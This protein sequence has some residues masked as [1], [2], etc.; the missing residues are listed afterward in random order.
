MAKAV[1]VK[2]E[3]VKA[4]KIKTEEVKNEKLVAILAYFL[5]GI[6]W[7]FADENMKNSSLAKFHTK[8]ILA[9]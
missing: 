3:K 8:K 2:N 5:V 1:K 6:I 4:G 9:F 7:Y